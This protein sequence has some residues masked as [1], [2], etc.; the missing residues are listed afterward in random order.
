MKR[1]MR[2]EVVKWQYTLAN[3]KFE[4]EAW[5]KILDYRFFFNPNTIIPLEPGPLGT[6]FEYSLCSFGVHN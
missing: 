4:L 1:I 5:E 3:Y 6:I 2:V